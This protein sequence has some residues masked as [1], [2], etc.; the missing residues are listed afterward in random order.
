MHFQFVTR[1]SDILT[2]TVM[3]LANKRKPNEFA[4]TSMPLLL[5]T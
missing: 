3:P 5:Q 1:C 4:L 2:K